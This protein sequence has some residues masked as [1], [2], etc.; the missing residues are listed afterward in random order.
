MIELILRMYTLGSEFF[1]K[2]NK[3]NAIDVV[4]VL[5]V[6]VHAVPFTAFNDT[7]IEL[8]GIVGIV[9]MVRFG[10]FLSVFAAFPTLYLMLQGLAGIV[11]TVLWGIA[12][13][14][15][16]LVMWSVLSMHSV[17]TI[18]SDDGDVLDLDPYCMEAFS[19]TSQTA[20]Y[21]FRT[22][23][24]GDSWGLCAVPIIAHAPWT[25]L[26][27]GGSQLTVTFGAANLILSVIVEKSVEARENDS[28]ARSRRQLQ[29]KLDFEHTWR[30]SLE[31][32]DQNNDGF[33]T[34]DEVVHSYEDDETVR[35]EFMK[36]GIDRT[37][38]RNLF[39]LLGADRHVG[40]SINDLVSIF[41]K[42]QL[43]DERVYSMT[44]RLLMEQISFMMRGRYLSRS[45]EHD[46]HGQRSSSDAQHDVHDQRS[47]SDAW[48]DASSSQTYKASFSDADQ[49]PS[50]DI[51]ELQA[52]ASDH[53]CPVPAGAA[54]SSQSPRS[55]HHAF[56]N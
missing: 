26:I 50:S 2:W 17:R 42:A 21:F 15:M 16:L 23:L 31:R 28:K 5:L 47:S 44:M 24:A 30:S 40:L 8:A 13:M 22:I 37:D 32:A 19:S 51:E 1:R 34:V 48:T 11:T 27:F 52:T 38:L 9:R 29:E 12:L 25:V 36:M 39:Y 41:Q 18:I 6:G 43:Q 33:L 53:A 45:G 56:P 14:G 54:S 3:W 49:P 20:M 46:V 4:I 35:V 55:D 7:A 10:R